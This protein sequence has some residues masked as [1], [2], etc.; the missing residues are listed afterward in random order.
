[1]SGLEALCIS[2]QHYAY[3]CRYGDL[4]KDYVRLVPQLCLAF[5]WVTEFIYQTHQHLVTSL[6]QPWLSSPH[7][8]TVAD[9]I[10]EK[11]G[12]LSNCWGFVDGTSVRPICRPG[13]YQEVM[14]N[15]HKRI[16]A[17]KFQA[18]TTPNGLIAH[19]FGPVEGRSHDVYIL[20]EPGLLPELEARS[21]DP[22]GNVLCIYGDPAYPL[23]PQL[24]AP[25]PGNNHQAFNA[26]MSKVRIS[27]EWSFG[28]IVNLFK[29]TD[30]KK[31]QKLLL[32]SCAKLYIVS[33]LLTNAH[34]CMYKNNTSTYFGLDPPTPNEYFQN[35]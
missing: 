17:N 19:L 7:L 27:V 3:P 25:F 11:G 15:G 10:H 24:Q 4:S 34:S 20:R 1:M 9:A 21:Y 12:A 29:F 18:V 6:D 32:S 16:H 31:T 22:D 13:I 5:K 14:Y 33:G 28:E 2:L 35:E 30:F 8:S 23:R 26:S